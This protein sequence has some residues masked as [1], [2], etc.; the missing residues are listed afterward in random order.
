MVDTDSRCREVAVSGEDSDL[1]QESPP[2]VQLMVAE[3]D[4]LS[5]DDWGG[6][7]A[8]PGEVLEWA[9][10]R[11]RDE[12]RLRLAAARGSFD[13][14]LEPLRE[15][16]VRDRGG[17]RF[18]SH[19]DVE[20]VDPGWREHWERPESIVSCPRRPRRDRRR[21]RTH[22][23]EVDHLTYAQ[24]VE[25]LRERRRRRGEALAARVR[26]ASA[27]CRGD[28]PICCCLLECQDSRYCVAACPCACEPH[29]S[30]A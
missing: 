24:V 5:E 12:P 26:G 21:W 17:R 10:T 8:E 4:P 27:N 20:A 22:S 11:L 13:P 3:G 30:G 28:E 23:V 25:I 15:D 7:P 6:P 14:P 18:P 16:A 29:P 2:S 19:L 1:G 9:L